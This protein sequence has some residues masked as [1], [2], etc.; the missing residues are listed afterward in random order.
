MSGMSNLL[1]INV[2]A[3]LER[4]GIKGNWLGLG[5]ANEDGAMGLVA[6]LEALAQ[7]ALSGACGSSPFGVMARPARIS[8]ARRKLGTVTRE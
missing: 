5:D 8:G 4:Y 7:T 6:E 3:V 2:A 1:S